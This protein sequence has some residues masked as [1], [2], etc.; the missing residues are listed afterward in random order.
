ME[1]LNKEV[2]KSGNKIFLTERECIS[3]ENRLRNSK[4]SSEIINFLIE[5]GFI[6]NLEMHR[7]L[8]KKVNEFAS[9]EF[10]FI[11]DKIYM[12]KYTDTFKV[13]PE[14][15]FSFNLSDVEVFKMFYFEMLKSQ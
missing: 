15:N 3:Y 5:E 13:K 1:K 11:S 4:Q 12:K 8:T 6:E 7:V 14:E 2:F 9:Y 10:K